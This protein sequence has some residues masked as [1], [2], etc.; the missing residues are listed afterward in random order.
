MRVFFA[1][2]DKG[3][4]AEVVTL[5]A[6]DNRPQQRLMTKGNNHESTH[7]T[8]CWVEDRDT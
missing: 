6:F 7:K 2:K 4:S 5:Q 3:Y 8:T 1:M